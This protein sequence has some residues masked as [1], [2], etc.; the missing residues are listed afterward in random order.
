MQVDCRVRHRGWLLLNDVQVL[1]ARSHQHR[2]DP[3]GDLCRVLVEELCLH[4]Q[5]GKRGQPCKCKRDI[6]QLVAGNCI[7][8][9]FQCLPVTWYMS[10]EMQMFLVTPFILIPVWHINQRFGSAWAFAVSL[11]PGIA[12]TCSVLAESAIRKWPASLAKG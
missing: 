3:D 7:I 11:L 6:L 5:P 10:A 8:S 12:I 1:R 4:H 9:C 2:S